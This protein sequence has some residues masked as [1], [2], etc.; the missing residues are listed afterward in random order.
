MCHQESVEAHVWTNH[1]LTRTHVLSFQIVWPADWKT[2][3]IISVDGVHCPFHEVQHPTLSKDPAW[4]SHK[5]KGPGVA[6]EFALSIYDSQLVWMRGP[7][8]ASVSDKAIYN[9]ELKAMIPD[10]CLVVAD[11]GYQDKKDPALATPNPR[12]PP[13]LLTFKARAR[14][15]Q[16]AFHSRLKRFECL[17]TK[18]RHSA[19]H[20]KACCEAVCV[21]IQ[22]EIELGAPLF[23][24]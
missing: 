15:R 21:I 23:D 16:E 6:Y 5:F 24:V 2:E 13:E 4:F 20:H 3:F 10:G 18:F 7:Y 19:Q 1:Q 12:D 11:G 17:K 8:K 14:M 22:Y 9:R